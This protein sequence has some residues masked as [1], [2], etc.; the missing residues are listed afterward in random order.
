M[1]L[2]DLQ[3]CNTFFAILFVYFLQEVVHL[4]IMK[5]QISVR[6]MRYKQVAILLIAVGDEPYIFMTPAFELI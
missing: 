3:I 4:I 6:F 5:C 1:V 2:V